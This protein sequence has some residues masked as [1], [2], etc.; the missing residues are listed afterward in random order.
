MDN[1]RAIPQG[2]MTVGEVAKRMGVT[3]RTLQYYDREG[4]FCPSALSEGGRRLY[5]DKD[6][7]KLHQIL[8][9]KSLGFSID[10]IK[11]RLT[12]LDTPAEIAAT[13]TDQGRAI[14]AQIDA[15][16]R[17]LRDIEILKAEVLKMQTVDFKKYAD[18]I[19]NVQMKNDN[20]W[21]I[22]YF[23]DDTLELLRRRFDRESGL[24]FIERFDELRDRAV[25]YSAAGIAPDSACGRKFAEEFWQ[26]ITEFTGGDMRMLP[27]L[28]K[29]GKLDTDNAEWQEKMDTLNAFIGP[30]LEAYFRDA[31][32][33]PF[34]VKHD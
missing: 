3:V 27:Q 9:L 34:E 8:S 20:Y 6:I 14:Q 1:D 11:N 18:I 4:L 23:D 31:G 28:M 30:A 26:L 16:A 5:T 32:I 33:D 13:L 22:K 19:V 7:V 17:S 15:L 21:L 2:Y 29:M 24:A 12:A 25:E 10:E